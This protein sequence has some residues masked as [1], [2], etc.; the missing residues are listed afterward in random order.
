MGNIDFENDIDININKN[1]FIFNNIEKTQS[2][3]KYYSNLQ[4]FFENNHF[5]DTKKNRRS[6]INLTNNKNN[7][8]EF[9]K[10]I[11]NNDN[12]DYIN[13]NRN[14]FN[15]VYDKKMI[16]ILKSLNL[17]NLINIF[18]SNCIYF[19]DLF[20]LTKKDLIEMKIPIGQRNRFMHF[21]E[22]FKSD[23]KIYDFNEIKKYLDIYKNNYINNVFIDENISNNINIKTI[24]N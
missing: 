3:K 7:F 8:H 17:D 14:K 11:N 15:I 20:L 1:D 10:N 2:E 5:K 19:N 9:I 13:N 4:K 18:A 21:F 12:Y 6:N 22:K 24:S 16:Y 23:A